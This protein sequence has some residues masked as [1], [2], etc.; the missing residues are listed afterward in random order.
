MTEIP[1]CP[2]AD[3]YPRTPNWA[4]PSG[5]CDCHFHVF[6]PTD[7]YPWS[8]ARGYTPPDASIES[9]LAM[10]DAIGFNR[11]VI[12]HPSVYGT[13]NSISLDFLDRFRGDENYT[14]RGVAVVDGT[15]SEAELAD[16]HERGMRG[17]RFNM[18]SKGGPPI[19]AI[20]NVADKI[21]PLGWHIQFYVDVRSFDIS[22]ML[23]LG[24]PI[25]V[26]HM[27]HMVPSSGLDHPGFRRLLTALGDG[28]A[29][30]KVS[31]AYRCTEL[32]RTPYDDVV[33]MAQALIQAN[34]ERCVY[35]SDWPHPSY[36]KPMPNDGDLVDA[37][38]VWLPDETD[39][40][41]LLVDNPTELYDF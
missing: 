6:G 12:V 7:R 39:R 5:A 20:R 30:V 4:V 21:R 29:W 37:L 24:L 38:A 17:V 15:V 9:Y 14:F 32:E 3:P 23:N 28:K 2:G 1:A 40:R 34:P 10:L 25:V 11:G 31:G 27:G 18:I 26:D 8:P 41:R 22:D 16:M 13:D 36:W 33:A 35:G 19:D